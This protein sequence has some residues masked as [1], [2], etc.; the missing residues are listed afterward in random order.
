MVDYFNRTAG[1][2]R[3]TIIYPELLLS[4][5]QLPHLPAFLP[6]SPPKVNK[7][8]QERTTKQKRNQNDR[9]A[10]E[11]RKP[12]YINQKGLNDLKLVSRGPISDISTPKLK[13]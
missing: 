2:N 9:D 5:A 13:K 1:K 10:A 7:R 4:E 12:D 8:R 3:P 6:V 11:E